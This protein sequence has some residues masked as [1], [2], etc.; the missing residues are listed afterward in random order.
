MNGPRNAS[1]EYTGKHRRDDA[2]GMAGASPWAARAESYGR[3]AADA[4][5]LP[6]AR[7]L[8]GVLRIPGARPDPGFRSEP[9][10]WTDAG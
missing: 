9:G 7:P 6:G 4:R 5:L 2:R 1:R 3:P 8:P 10:P